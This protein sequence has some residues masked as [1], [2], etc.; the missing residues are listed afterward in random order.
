MRTAIDRSTFL[1][2]S[3]GVLLVGFA[4][5]T[6]ALAQTGPAPQATVNPTLLGTPSNSVDAWLAVDRTGL[7]TLYSGK[8][9][10]GT[11]TETAL[12]QLVADELGVPFKQ[13]RMIA[14]I[15]GLTPD[16]G[17]TSGSQTIQTGS[18]PMRRAAATA[19]MKLMELGAQHFQ[20]ASADLAT[21]DGY[22]MPRDGD[23]AR[24]VGYGDL[25]GGR[26]FEL[27]VN[28]QAPLM[29]PSGFRAVGRP[30][31]RVD[32][33]EKAYGTFKYAQN[34]RI[35][36]MWHARVIRPN[37]VGA[38][39]VSLDR[40]SIA[41]LKNVRIVQKGNFVAVAAPKEWDAIRAARTLEVSWSG[42]GLPA[43]SELYDIIRKTPADVK[44]AQ[45]AGDADAAL[46]NA[47]KVSASYFGPSKR[48]ARS[49]RRAALRR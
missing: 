2:R 43:Q 7:V 39:F 45:Q 18:I 22:V 24:A 38:S 1:K 9:E 21:R 3:G 41:A 33:P 25:I 6:Q 4:T 30:L 49:V 8:V 10:L 37:P 47:T 20:V 36:G 11:G 28:P 29:S 23:R 27:T 34:V 16:Q 35:P 13:V 42:G 12:L 48:T 17:V 14:G 32:L 15:T 19:R 31:K 5:G 44:V 26:K 40:R 46:G